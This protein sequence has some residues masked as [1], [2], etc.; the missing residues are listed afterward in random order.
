MSLLTGTLVKKDQKD[1]SQNS[2]IYWTEKSVI[3]TQ[4]ATNR[5]LLTAWLIKIWMDVWRY[6][7]TFVRKVS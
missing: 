2:K 3:R 1:V 5:V 4:P 7:A 6:M